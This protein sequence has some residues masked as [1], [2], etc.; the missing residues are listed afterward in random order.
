MNTIHDESLLSSDDIYA[1]VYIALWFAACIVFAIA[2]SFIVWNLDEV[3]SALRTA[4]H[5]VRDFV[6]QP[7]WML[8][9]V[10]F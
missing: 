10:S 5:A 9:S 2:C 7:F 3:W 6:E 1:M 8:L 4:G